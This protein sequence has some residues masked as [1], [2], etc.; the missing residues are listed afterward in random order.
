[1]RVAFIGFMGSG[2]STSGKALAADLG[3]EFIDLDKYIEENQGKTI[4]SIFY[5]FGEPHFREIEKQA[6]QEIIETKQNDCVLAC[7]GGI[8]LNEQNRK[9]LK[10]NTNCFFLNVDS[11]T[12]T[13]RLFYQKEN[14]PLLRDKNRGEMITFIEQELERR[15]RFYKETGFEITLTGQ[16]DI[17]FVLEKV[18]SK[19]I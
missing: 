10:Q 7:G 16:E 3:I 6:L 2:K 18:K 12:L 1:M 14:R 13:D 4:A 8:I 11:T 5:E 9:L 19:I 15:M 17:H